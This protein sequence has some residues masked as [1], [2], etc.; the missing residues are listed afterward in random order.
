MSLD[1]HRASL[2]AAMRLPMRFR[3]R[4]PPR[5]GSVSV[6]RRQLTSLVLVGGLLALA[7]C[8]SSDAPDVLAVAPLPTTTE[9]SGGTTTSSTTTSTSVATTT[10]TTTTTA[11]IAATTVPLTSPTTTSSTSTTSTLPPPPMTSCEQ[12]VHIGDSTGVYLWESQYVGGDENTM[13]ARY[14]AVGVETVFRDN[15]GG[16]SI[17]ERVADW[18]TN[19]FEVAVA[20]RR[21]GFRGCWV[22]MIGTN[23]AANVAAGASMTHAERILRMLYVIGDEPVLWVDTVTTGVSSAY[24]NESMEAWN[25][26]LEWIASER[27]NLEV[28]RWSDKVRPEWFVADGIHYTR[29]GHAWRAAITAL[30][31]AEAFPT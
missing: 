26:V 28:L 22:L 5:T 30:A 19:A 17:N 14:R 12:V 7:A 2:A 27:S 8:S 31:L 3:F 10:T 15:N 6:A 21:N 9:S 4:A 11:P 20:A 18:Q 23:D 13:E 16:R 29:D 25:N 24:R 1:H